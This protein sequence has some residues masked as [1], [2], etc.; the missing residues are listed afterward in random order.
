MFARTAKANPIRT[1][2][3]VIN[4]RLDQFSFLA[5]GIRQRA[6]NSCVSAVLFGVLV[7]REQKMIDALNFVSS[8]RNSL[9]RRMR[10]SY[11]SRSM[12]TSKSLW[13]GSCH[14]E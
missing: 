4:Y 2:K 5:L 13:H 8:R 7:K 3:I 12:S 10:I 14:R 6:N 9:I 11:P 1:M